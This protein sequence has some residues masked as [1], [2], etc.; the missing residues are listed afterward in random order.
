M[1]LCYDNA[2]PIPGGIV[3]TDTVLIY[4]GGDTPHVWS[5]AEVAGQPERF[6]LPAYVRSYAGVDPHADATA[7][8]QWLAS[9]H[10]P[11]G[12]AT[13]LDL[14]ELVDPAYVAS[15]GGAMHAA[16][17]LVLP[18]GSTSTLFRNPKLDGYFVADPG[19]GSMYSGAVATQFLYAGS[20][21]LSWIDDSVPLWDTAP[22]IVPPVTPPPLP[23][24]GTTVKPLGG[25]VGKLAAPVIAICPTSTGLGYTEVG[26]DGGTFTYGDAVFLGSLAAQ[27]LNAP[28]V[29]AA[30]TPDGRGLYLVGTDGG[31]FAL[32]TAQFYGSTGGQHLNA[33]VVSISVTTTGKGYWLAA[34]DGGVFTFGDARFYGSPA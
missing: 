16:G 24:G 13:V 7:F 3:G 29:D 19:A 30:L 27:H 26:A 17:F 1:H 21:D 14:E 8:I 12:I 11:P 6:R 33:P 15:F 20:Y 31:V 34:S 28:I 2:Y 9:V 18:Y 22:P 25:P 32:G 4:S 5:A 23:A 10:A